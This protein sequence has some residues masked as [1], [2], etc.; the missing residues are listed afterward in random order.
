M[1]KHIFFLLSL[2]ACTACTSEYDAVMKNASQA[3]NVGDDNAFYATIERTGEADG[4]TKVF[5]D[6]QMRVLWNADDRITVFN[7][8]NRNMQYRFTGETGANAGS[9]E[10]VTPDEIGLWFDMDN[11]YS[12]YPYNENMI[13]FSEGVISMTL[14]A[15]QIYLKDSFGRGANTMVS[16][17]EDNTLLFRNVGGF[18][19]FKLYG[20]GVNVKSITFRGNNHE[21]LAGE[22]SV[23]MTLGGTPTVN[24]QYYSTEELT[25]TCETP[26]TLNGEADH[27]TEFWFVLPPT[28]FTKGFTI[29]VTD[30]QGGIFVKSTASSISVP[31]NHIRRMSPIQVVPKNDFLHFTD[32]QF[33]DYCLKN[34]DTDKDGEISPLEASTVERIEVETDDILTFAGIEQFPCLRELIAMPRHTGE[35]GVGIGQDWRESGY[36]F[37]EYNGYNTV[38]IVHGKLNEL[39]LSGNPLLEILNCSGNAL[40]SVDLTANQNLREINLNYNP[41]LSILK[42]GNS[43]KLQTLRLTCTSLTSMDLSGIPEL[44]NLSLDRGE[45]I[46]TVDLSHNTKL[47]RLGLDHRGITH[48]DVSNNVQLIEFSCAGNALTNIDLTN[49]KNLFWLSLA[50]NKIQELNVSENCLLSSLT[51]QNNQLSSLDVTKLPELQYFHFGNYVDDGETPI[52]TIS[53]IDLSNNSKLIRFFSTILNIK[54]IDLSD[55]EKLEFVDCSY[56]KLLEELDVSSSSIL[57]TLWCYDCPSL[58]TIYISPGQVFNCS[59]DATAHFSYKGEGGPYCSTD[60]TQDGAVTQLQAASIGNGIN[61]VLMGDAFSDR[62]IA[63]GTYDQVMNE[64]MEAFFSVEPYRSFR[65]LFNVYSVKVVSINETYDGIHETAL[66]TWFGDGTLVGG[67]DATVFD[68]A[69]EVPGFNADQSVICVVMNKQ[70]YAGTCYMYGTLSF[71]PEKGFYFSMKDGSGAAIA[72]V[73][74]GVDSENFSHIVQHEAGGHGFA[75]LADEYYYP[76]GGSISQDDADMLEAYHATG[77]YT[78]VD[79]K[80]STN[81]VLWVDLLQDENYAS[82]GLGIFEGAFLYEQGVYRPTLNSLMN[83]GTGHFNAPSRKTIYHIIGQRAYGDASQFDYD[84][85][86][87]YDAINRTNNNNVSGWPNYRQTILPPLHSPVVKNQSWKDVISQSKREHYREPVKANQQNKL[88]LEIKPNLE[89]NNNSGQTAR[90]SYSDGSFWNPTNK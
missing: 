76:G 82:E 40:T 20:S 54:A 12:V 14:P 85:F 37:D 58:S 72:Y 31:R 64:T 45:R 19:S 71:E 39:D 83:S 5:A 44:L 3:N 7:K 63:D 57:E 13:I 77:W 56:N 27:F 75:K 70:A 4:Q 67:Q 87:A 24:M 55:K 53:E 10:Q 51:L 41:D 80:A 33:K 43:N 47:Q 22:S 17:T 30:D 8:N 11:I 25:L 6:N 36:T 88:N 46:G 23:T 74:L 48:L 84:S 89:T 60:F 32:A 68:Y 29:T 61:I 90:K 79:T 52:N 73:P 42:L 18:I 78:N 15:E 28:D 50:F 26:V 34:F 65:E 62:L 9:F 59:K 1:K 81:T 16:V 49:N 86:V 69:N 2:L 21:K 38:T 35:Y 66:G